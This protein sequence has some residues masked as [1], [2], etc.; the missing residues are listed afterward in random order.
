MYFCVLN[1]L[2]F[3]IHS[4]PS[5]PAIMPSFRPKPAG[6]A[7][8]AGSVRLRLGSKTPHLPTFATSSPLGS[9]GAL[10]M[11]ARA[12][13]A[14]LGRSKRPLKPARLHWGAQK[15]RSSLLGSAKALEIARP[16]CSNTL[17]LPTS[18]KSS[19]LGS[20]GSPDIAARAP[21]LLI[22][23]FQ[24]L[25]LEF[26]R[27]LIP[28][29]LTFF[30]CH[31]S[32]RSRHFIKVMQVLQVLGCAVHCPDPSVAEIITHSLLEVVGMLKPALGH[33][34]NIEGS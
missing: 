31:F 16:G 11:T 10:E 6:D 7:P 20:A 5:P 33:T 2:M 21:E 1:L 29:S 19:P 23:L 8:R 12:R 15:G 30:I 28:E 9:A 32:S 4:G 34:C 14:P 17:H 26:L 22:E 13:S 18:P 24:V 25:L 27:Q 3:Y